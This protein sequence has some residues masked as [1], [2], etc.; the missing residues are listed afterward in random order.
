M[1]SNYF[2][3]I[4]SS[5]K[6]GFVYKVDNLLSIVNRIIEV[7]VLIFIWTAIYGDNVSI[8]GMNLKTLIIYYAIA[9]SLGHIMTWGINEYMSSSIKNGRINMEL[10]YPI[11]YIKYFFC[12]KL[13]NVLRQLIVISIPTFI[14]LLIL[15]NIHL[16]FNLINILFFLLITF[17][18]VIIIFFIEF[19][20]GLMAFYTTSGWG[21]QVLKKSI[22]TILSGAI[23]PIQFFP[24][25]IV[26]IL[27]ILP[28]S[29]L[30]YSPITTLL[31]MNSFS[32]IYTILLRQLIWIVVLYIVS[33]IIYNKAIKN[34]TIYGG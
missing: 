30:V 9:Y 31:G 18:S 32:N 20:F 19:I 2:G 22:V 1:L 12:Y 4:I 17:L 13:G 3:V 11:D 34:V 33:K 23:A 6:K 27:K 24:L 8:N 16:S 25:V 15:Y 28:F 26:K 10:L 14:I 21:L 7:S 5:F 29:D